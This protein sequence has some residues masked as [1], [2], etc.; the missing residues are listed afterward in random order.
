M[1]K[2]IKYFK[3]IYHYY[4][5][6]K[7]KATIKAINYKI[8]IK[9]F[10]KMSTNMYEKYKNFNLNEDKSKYGKDVIFKDEKK[11]FIFGTV[12]YF[13][14]GGG[15]RSSQLSKIFNKMGFS[16]YYIYAYECSEN[17][18]PI[19]QMP[20]TYHKWVDKVNYDELE[21]AVQKDDIFIFEAPIKKFNK[22]IALAKFK[23]AKIVYENIDNWETS[24]GSMFFD[25][26]TLKAMLNN[27]DMIVST[28]K[29][30]VEQTEKYVE[31]YCEKKKKVYYLANAVDD[32]LFEPRKKYEKP[33]DLVTGTKTLLYY[34]SLWGEWFDWD[35]IETIAK[36]D[37]N[38]AINLIGDASGIKEIVNRMPKNVHFLGIKK[39]IELPA[40]LSYVDFPI[41][42]FKIGNIGDCVSPL[43]IFEYI[44]MN[45]KV[46]STRLPD[47]ENYPNVFAS[48]NV[49]EW[50]KEIYSEDT[51][52]D[53][54]GRDKFIENNNWY[55]RCTT[56]ISTLFPS[57]I[58]E[59]AYGKIS[60]IILNYNNKNVIFKCVE[61]LL[62]YND[63]YNYQ[64]VVVD[65]SS[66]D[67]SYEKLKQ[68][69]NDKITLVRNNKNGCS[70]GRNLGVE[71][72]TG[73][74]IIFLDS[75]EWALNK[76]WLDTYVK[77]LINNSQ[78]GTIGWGAGWFNKSGFAYN[79]VDS[80]EF[81]F[82]PPNILC[83]CDIGYLATCG[84]IMTKK[85]FEKVEGFDLNYDPTCYE[86]T[87]LTLKIRNE[88]KEAYYSSYLGVGHLPHQTTK[89]GTTEHDKLI[90]KKGEYF[91]AKWKR[92]NPDLIFKY[93]K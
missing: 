83:R 27:S 34:G 77:T 43:K 29:K 81:K 61:S 3:K 28:A 86:D 90:R 13:D 36:H 35:I 75:D 84:F 10:G 26:E 16:V 39:Q 64:I 52:I 70:S 23:S 7:L 76:Y 87:D 25:R 33:D 55:N 57:K 8:K 73:E 59:C 93:V 92:I 50:L 9:L 30:L 42:P 67:G 85:L 24:L 2:I 15:Q 4:R 71:N 44:A 53:I 21:E 14:V 40:Y 78:I 89:S 11:I 91:I 79:V 20:I 51:C 82:M 17:D 72:A 46:L 45:K 1:K 5:A 62:K 38:I 80:Y 66:S 49:D 19:I 31:E 88:G 47:I 56:I 58:L 60:V 6:N 63:R 37:E 54:D 65:N 18:I 68:E 41:L 12:P 48:G 69:Y 22:Y 74:Y 32:E